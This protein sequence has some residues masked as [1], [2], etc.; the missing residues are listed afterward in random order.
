MNIFRNGDFVHIMFS[1]GKEK[2]FT[3]ISQ[4]EWDIINDNINNEEFLHDRYF[5][6]NKQIDI[7]EKGVEN[8]K[9]LVKRGMS[10]YLPSISEVSLPRDL[11]E[12]IIE[13]ERE[14]DEE[15]L[16]T[17]FNFWKLVSMNP[18]ARVRDNLFWFCKRWDVKLTPTGL[19]RAYRNAVLKE[20]HK[21]T[22]E[23][24]KEIINNYYKQ[25]FLYNNV[26]PEL[27]EKYNNIV[28][29]DDSPVFTD[30]YSHTTTIK[31]GQPVSIP[32]EECNPD[33]EQSCSRG[34]HV[35]GREWLNRG[36]FGDTALEVLVNP[37][38][39]VAVP[40]IDQYGKMRTCRYF[41]IAIVDFDE[42]GYIIEP[43]YDMSDDILYLKTLKENKEINNEDF[44]KYEI[45]H[46]N[47]ASREDIY[48]SI[49]EEFSDDC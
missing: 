21:F 34:L 16:S 40:T 37:A 11:V 39:V 10:V 42:E 43:E 29:E 23:E 6:E 15:K 30:H 38:D 35:G 27:E 1:D 28:N 45:F 13:A 24:T 26:T 25:K 31:L 9:Y 7:L 2:S 20:S 18:D 4:E 36:Y 3:F 5:S 17:F 33:Q 32:R 41:P 49:L 47:F 48:D 12:K 19:I 44:N 46:Y 14:D 8:S 22:V